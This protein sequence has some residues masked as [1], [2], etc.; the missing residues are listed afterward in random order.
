[1]KSACNETHTDSHTCPARSRSL[2]KG[3]TKAPHIVTSNL[4]KESVI[5]SQLK[6]PGG[7]KR[8]A[9]VPFVRR[10]GS[11]IS[12]SPH[13]R[14]LI[15]DYVVESSV[16]ASSLAR[17]CSVNVL[18]EKVKASLQDV[19]RGLR[20][21]LRLT[22]GAQQAVWP[23]IEH[24]YKLSLIDDFKLISLRRTKESAA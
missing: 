9:E 5:Y 6:A 10:C 1:M 17:W 14:P 24:T 13:E 2:K 21:R 19:S 23:D 12:L 11:L 16:Q 7:D 3:A 22:P 15:Y 8:A 20:Q 18:R 4:K